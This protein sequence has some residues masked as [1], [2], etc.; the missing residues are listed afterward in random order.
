[1]APF[2]WYSLMASQPPSLLHMDVFWLPLV[3]MVY[4]CGTT[5][6]REQRLGTPAEESG[7][8]LYS[9]LYQLCDLGQVS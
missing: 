9:A 2:S 1:M 4:L 5:S 7:W 3:V 6:G 8:N